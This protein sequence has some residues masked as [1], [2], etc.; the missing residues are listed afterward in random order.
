M[1]DMAETSADVETRSSA[2]VNDNGRNTDTSFAGL[3]DEYDYQSPQRGQILEGEVLKVHE[4]AVLVDVGLKR[5]A[6][7]PRKDLDRLDDST[8]EQLEPGAE[9]MVYVLRP[10]NRGGDLIVSINKALEYEDWIRAGALVKSGEVVEADVTDTNKG[11]ALIQ[12]GRLRGFVPQ[13][14][15]TSI[16]RGVSGE[17]R[18]E[19][20]ERLV[21]Q[22]LILK[23]IE[24]EQR[25]DRLVL[26]ERAAQREARSTRL[27]EL[28]AGQVLTGQ[29]VG[30]KPYGAFVDVGGVDGLV[31]VSELAW[32]RVEHPREV[33][34]VGD[35]V[36]VQVKSVDVERERISLSRK[37]MLPNPWDM[38]E[39]DHPIGTLATGTVSN[40]V[41]FGAFVAL[42]SGLEG[43]VHVSRMSSTGVSEPGDLVRRGDEV[44]VRIL[45]IN[46]ARERITLS[47]DAVSS[48]E[49]AEW[50]EARAEAEEEGE[51]G[52]EAQHLA[53]DT[54][55]EATLSPPEPEWE[56]ELLDREETDVE[57][58]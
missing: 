6:F 38:V 31:H 48:E 25:R 53:A 44:L 29:V 2:E 32:R 50:M 7:V 28:E 8:L 57:E 49:H 55:E 5:D 58:G 52:E 19:A 43:L 26:S 41:D 36:E 18:R 9:I 11:G 21:G 37:A 3:L 56:T 47:M 54:G 34:S 13:S 35:E 40:V 45:D 15:L 30:L 46:P 23:V 22:T 16:P 10:Q 20:M 51:E 33:L 42:P 17:E 27:A 39:L 1:V 14:H 24:V 4:D 12:F